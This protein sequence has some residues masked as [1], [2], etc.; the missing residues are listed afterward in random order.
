LLIALLQF[1]ML[2]F[3]SF[4][5]I[6]LGVVIY[7]VNSPK[8]TEEAREKNGDAASFV[9]WLLSP[10]FQTG[11]LPADISALALDA[12]THLHQ[13][14]ADHCGSA[15]RHDSCCRV[16]TKPTTVP[17]D[18]NEDNEIEASAFTRL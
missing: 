5:L 3:A 18:T 10:S 8:S 11:P 7:T 15:D 2:Y 14:F 17:V 1:H 13:T 6:V 4:G 9:S 16:D 12:G